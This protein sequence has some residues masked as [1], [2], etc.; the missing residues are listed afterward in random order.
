MGQQQSKDELLYQQVNYGNVDGIKSLRSEGAGLEWID[1][2]GKTPLMVAC[3]NPTLHNVAETLIELGANVNAYRPGRQAGTPLHHAAKRGLDQTVKLLLSHGANALV[4]NDDCQTPLDIARG[5]G[6]SNIVRTIEGHVCL[7]SGWLRELYGPGFLELL[8]PQLLSRKVWVVVVPCGS[9]NLRKP[10]KL[11]LALYASAQDAQPRL[12]IPL[13]K[14]NLEE[15]NFNLPDPT[16]VVTAIASKA[17]IKLAP[18]SDKQQLQRFCN[19]CKGI[20]QVPH[21]TFPFNTQVPAVQATAPPTSEDEEVSIAINASRQAAAHERPPNIDSHSISSTSS[22]NSTESSSPRNSYI[23]GASTTHKGSDG[24]LLEDGPGSQVQH[25][26]TQSSIPS[27]VRTTLENPTPVSIPSA[28]PVADA[29]IDDGPIH[30]PSIDSSPVDLSSA[31]VDALPAGLDEKIVDNAT[32]SCTIC[33]DAPVEGAC[34]PCGHMAGCMSCL[35]EIKAKKWG[36]PVCR[37]N[38]NQ[39]I[40]IYAV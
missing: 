14:A 9:R 17:R 13:W 26:Q 3:M 4:M 12:I 39:V 23:W 34:I 21:P 19:A 24:T 32:S 10:F 15:P 33:L 5:K 11:E 20:P 1:S 36:C 40:R 28:P 7:F 27:V 31:A 25:I 22:G 18:E 16:A 30:Y 38:I 8:A 29:V 37:A 2:E 35:N 6:Y